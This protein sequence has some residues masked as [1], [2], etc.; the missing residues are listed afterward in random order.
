MGIRV[1]NTEKLVHSD[2]SRS[3]M[4]EQEISDLSFSIGKQDGAGV[5]AGQNEHRNS[6]NDGG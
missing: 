4:L 2:R 1:A 3:V 6:K 5:G